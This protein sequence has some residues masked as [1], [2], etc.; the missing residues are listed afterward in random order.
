[1]SINGKTCII[2]EQL[3]DQITQ[4][5]A[6]QV[7]AQFPCVIHLI[8]TLGAGKTRFARSLI[9]ALGHQGPVKS[10]TYTLV[11]PYESLM[12]PTY[13][14]DL[15]RLADPEELEFIGIREY[16]AQKALMLIEWPE[17][18]QGFLPEPDLTLELSLQVDDSD[19]LTLPSVQRLIDQGAISEPLDIFSANTFQTD[20]S[21]TPLQTDTSVT[22]FQTSTSITTS[23]TS[24]SVASEST[25]TSR[26]GILQSSFRVLRANAQTELGQKLLNS[27]NI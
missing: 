21:V 27:W 23:K 13:H 26:S 10:P 6:K 14:F 1:M 3:L 11:E 2:N 18:G 8:G 25:K 17:K 24:T 7:Q 22:P 16:V 9:Q 19:A 12:P 5:L 15:Y 4:D 20:T